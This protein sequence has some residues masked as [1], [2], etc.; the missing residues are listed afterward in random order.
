ML[1]FC[2][3]AFVGAVFGFFAAAILSVG[4]DDR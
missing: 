3:G 4:G 2:I 1:H